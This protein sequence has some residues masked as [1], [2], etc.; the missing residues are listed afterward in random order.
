MSTAHAGLLS[1]LLPAPYASQGAV[2]GAELAAE[3]AVLDA[4]LV[5][6]DRLLAEIDPATATE[7]LPLFEYWLGLPE[8][9]AISSGT[10]TL[11]RRRAAASARWYGEGGLSLDYFREV[12]AN[13]GQPGAIVEE[14]EAAWNWRVT[15]PE[16]ALVS[17]FSAGSAVAGQP[18]RSWQTHPLACLLARLGPAH[19]R[20]WLAFAAEVDLDAG[21]DPELDAAFDALHEL[22]HVTYPS[23][24]GV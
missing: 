10:Q 9:C 13:A 16:A 4:A 2:M 14:L 1:A 6:A 24:F 17:Y 7:L 22:L 23:Q 8:R 20:L 18:V 19:C 11:A 21:S 3:G 12:C 5:N 15:V